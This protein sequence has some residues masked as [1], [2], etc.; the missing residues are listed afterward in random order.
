MKGLGVSEVIVAP[1]VS[2]IDEK[3][4][5][6]CLKSALLKEVDLKIRVTSNHSINPPSVNDWAVLSLLPAAM[7]HDATL[8]VKGEI[9]SHLYSNIENVMAALSHNNPNWK[10]VAVQPEHVSSQ[11]RAQ[12]R[13]R[14]VGFSAGVDSFAT[15]A[16]YSKDPMRRITDLT[17][18]NV[19][20]LGETCDP[21]VKRLFARGLERVQSASKA[22]N[23]NWIAID[24]NF[25]ET[26]GQGEFNFLHTLTLRNAIMASVLEG[27]IDEYLYS[28]SGY[29]YADVSVGPPKGLAGTS[30][31]DP[32]FMPM[33]SSNN[34]RI[35]P[36]V[37]DLVRT[38]KIKLVSDFPMSFDQLDVCLLPG[39]SRMELPQLN[40]SRCYKCQMTMLAL[41]AHGKLA[42]YASVFDLDCYAKN[43][44]RFIENAVL[45]APNGNAMKKELVQSFRKAGWSVPSVSLVR[46]R[47]TGGRIRR[48]IRK[49]LR[50][51]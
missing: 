27:S 42:N 13:R 22:L 7:K 35:F 16:R 20:T 12:V 37:H 33:V 49:I 21:D 8:S 15:L 41:D 46:A 29:R 2:M 6:L 3:A 32:V 43:K 38:E 24:S 18:G 14:A 34:I 45:A 51:R 11:R 4:F 48:N 44:K 26:L 47:R 50:I 5:E 36:A 9:S 39:K 25:D 30:A 1:V 19:G 10:P 17:Y 23:T 31:M 28:S 40:C